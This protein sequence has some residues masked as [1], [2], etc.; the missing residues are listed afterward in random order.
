MTRIKFTT[1]AVSFLLV[2]SITATVFSRG[3]LIVNRNLRREV[4]EMVRRREQKEAE[5]ELLRED[6]ISSSKA[7]GD[8]SESIFIAELPAESRNT[9]TARTD[10]SGHSVAEKGFEG[11]SNTVIVLISL[12]SAAAIT[13]ASSFIPAVRRLEKEKCR[14]E[15]KEKRGGPSDYDDIDLV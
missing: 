6:L 7:S 12:G 13:A 4:D 11:L 8:E 9:E 15:E 2:F 1:F 14:S 3:G 5:V 10:I